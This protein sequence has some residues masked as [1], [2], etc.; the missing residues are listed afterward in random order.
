MGVF[1]FGIFATQAQ[2]F[3]AFDSGCNVI[4][5]RRLLV[6]CYGER[7]GDWG[8][9]NASHRS[10]SCRPTIS[11]QHCR[12]V[13]IDVGKFGYCRRTSLKTAAPGD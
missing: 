7:E 8:P 2:N 1:V 3:S 12:T 10:Q 5:L 13:T 6:Y 11:L 9:G 4:V